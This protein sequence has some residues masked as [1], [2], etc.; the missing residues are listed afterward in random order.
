MTGGPRPD[1]PQARPL[2]EAGT[3]ASL[4]CLIADRAHD[5]DAGRVWRAPRNVE[6]VLPARRRRT[7]PQPRVPA[8]YPARHVG[9]R[10]LG[11]LE[12]GR[13]VAT[14]Y[15]PYAPRRLGFPSARAR[16]CAASGPDG[17]PRGGPWPRRTHAHKPN[18]PNRGKKSTLFL[19]CRRVDL[20][21]PRPRVP[22]LCGVGG[23]LRLA[24]ERCPERKKPMPYDALFK[25][26]MG[27]PLVVLHLIR[28]FLKPRLDFPLRAAQLH[29]MDKEWITP[30]LRHRVSDKVWLLR[31][32]AGRPRLALLLEGQSSYA[33]DMT[34]RMA[35]YVNGLLE[36]LERHGLRQA[37]GAPL[38]IMPLVF[39]VGRHPWATP[40]YLYA[41][42][43]RLRGA[44]DFRP[45]TTID[46]HAFADRA[47]PPANL[48][49]GIIAWELDC[50][51]REG[52]IGRVG[53]AARRIIQQELGPL[54]ADSPVVLRNDFARYL[55]TRL[56]GE[57][58]GIPL[59]AEAFVSL[60]ALEADMVTW[61][62]IRVALRQDGREEG[63]EEGME[64]GIE[65]G[66]EQEAARKL[67]EFVTLYWNEATGQAFQARLAHREARL[68]PT[69]RDLRAAYEEGR[70]PCALLDA[71]G[72]SPTPGA[73]D[74][75]SAVI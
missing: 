8:R 57:V 25:L 7:H 65:R 26:L 17:R 58:P 29:D 6:A 27:H 64:R 32:P 66:I 19:S 49:S 42:S 52:K 67:A 23:R 43:E 50:L 31:D 3:D 13:R 46:I 70:D 1:R 68:W 62:E 47:L 18:L 48:V 20:G 71:S 9:A 22:V 35:A 56:Q 75:P 4:S 21:M 15:A 55:A 74:R 41:A 72:T 36:T 11:G 69:L 45:G 28:G 51:R 54:L 16:A 5:R 44:L 38:E 30:D 39:H 10:S 33:A 59:R 53:Q 2:G 14:R 24:G 34:V 40:W 12:H 60:E 37:H 63:I 73:N 61:D